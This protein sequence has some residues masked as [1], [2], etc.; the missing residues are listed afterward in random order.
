MRRLGE[1]CQICV[2][3]TESRALADF[4][5]DEMR[6]VVSP[7]GAVHVAALGLTLCGK[8]FAD[9]E[10]DRPCVIC[11]RAIEPQPRYFTSTGEPRHMLCDP[12]EL[13]QDEEPTGVADAQP[14]LVRLGL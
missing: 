5:R 10:R 1:R 12:E 11:G 2:S 14:P 7:I 3:R 9:W 6:E 4:P 13:W 8:S